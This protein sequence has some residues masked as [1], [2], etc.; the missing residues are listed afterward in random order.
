MEGEELGIGDLPMAR[1]VGFV[2]Q[3]GVPALLWFH[4]SVA[5]VVGLA[6]QSMEGAGA[7]A[8]SMRGKAY[9]FLLLGNERMWSAACRF[10]YALNW[11]LAPVGNTMP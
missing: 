3:R 5:V 2:D 11:Q 9:G 6:R 10:S 7:N 4:V 1:A 8:L